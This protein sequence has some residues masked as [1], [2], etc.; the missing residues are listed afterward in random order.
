MRG[1][2]LAEGR[3]VNDL[4]EHVQQ[5]QEHEGWGR[6][7]AKGR[8]VNGDLD[9]AVERWIHDVVRLFAEHRRPSPLNGNHY[10][11]HT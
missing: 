3:G 1:R 11:S 4:L 8:G 6:I 9:V 2:I 7:L 10:Y 5:T